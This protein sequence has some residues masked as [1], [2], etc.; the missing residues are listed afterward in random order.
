MCREGA[1]V[2]AVVLRGVR[3]VSVE[4]VPEPAI[5]APS[6]AIV[7]ITSAAICGSDLHMY[8]GRTVATAGLVLGHEPLGVVEEVGPSV[9]GVRKGDRVLVPFNIACGV[10]FNCARGFTS[11]CL[12]V[13]TDAAGG[14]YGYFGMGPYRGAQAE[15]LRVPFA[16]RN[17]LKVPG[18]P[19]DAWEDDF[20]L[21]ADVFPTGWY[22]NELAGVGEGSTVAVFGAGPV[23]IMAAYSASLRGASEIYVVEGVDDR[24]AMAAAIGATPIDF[25][26]GDPVE[27]IIAIRRRL[28]DGKLALGGEK[29]LGVMCGIEAVGYQAID[30]ADPAMPENPARVLEDLIRLVN[31]T[32]RIGSVGLYVPNDPGGIN[33]HAKRGEFRLSFGKLWEKGLSLGT[34]QTPVARFAPALADLIVSGKAKPSFLVSHRLPLEAAPDAYAKFEQHV[35][36]YTKVVLRP[37]LQASP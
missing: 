22:A 9:T 14:A 12:A 2:R 27:Q 25:R 37:S 23:G 5:E 6:D 13:N 11:A 31:P 30:W 15:Y 18:E 21:L 8:A 33:P 34:G 20:V 17:C 29:M 1:C 19:F 16:D 28:S 24:L 4:Q 35:E 3:E 36:G 10:C 32:G 26:R 7:R